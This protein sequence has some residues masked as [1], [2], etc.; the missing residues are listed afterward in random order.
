MEIIPASYFECPECRLFYRES[1]SAVE[2]MI[3][4]H[5][6]EPAAAETFWGADVIRDAA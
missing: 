3:V 2:H 4:D 5:W 6:W 1:W